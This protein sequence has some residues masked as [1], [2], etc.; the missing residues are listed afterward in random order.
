MKKSMKILLAILIIAIIMLIIFIVVKNASKE[1]VVE[2]KDYL[3]E[4]VEQYL[5][6]Q[7]EPHYHLETKDSKPNYNVS[8]FKVFT[9]IA[10]LGIKEKNDEIYVYVWALVESYYV[11]DGKLI[12]NSGSSM[13]YKFILKNEEVVDYEIPLDGKE[14]NKSIKKIFPLDIQEKLN[15]QLVDNNKIDIEVEKYYSYLDIKHDELENNKYIKLEDLEIDYNLSKMIE[16][17]CYILLNSNI[18]Y[19]I[20]ELDDFMDNVENNISDEIRIVQYTI[21][22]QP[23]LTNLE[24]KDNKFIVK[25]DNRRDGYAAKDEKKIITKEYDGAKYKLLKGNTPNSETNF[26]VYYPLELKDLE[27]NTTVNICNYAKRKKTTDSRF[28]IEFNDEQTNKEIVDVLKKGENNKY[29]YNI[30]SYKGTVDIEINDKKMS[31]RDALINNEI[32]VEEIL[33]KAQKDAFEDKIIF[34]DH[35]LD[36]GSTIYIY[37]DYAIIKLNTLDGNNDLYI[38]VPSMNIND[39]D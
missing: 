29:N 19:N 25:I 14:Y 27:T 9:D 30:Y 3:Y 15:E 2:G 34:G 35:F 36:G 1:E 32:S 17:E 16:D 4:K 24:Y 10:N 33:E 38:G 37:D 22:G 13:P 23:I 11:Q 7:E 8:D 6:S 12:S 21:E 5:I 18:V 28:K 26:I 39:L 20:E 31:L